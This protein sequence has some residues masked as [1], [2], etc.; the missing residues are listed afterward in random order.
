MNYKAVLFDLDGTLLNTLED[1]A[2]SMNEALKIM[3]LPS[4]PV[5]KYKILVGDGVDILVS[6]A[7]PENLRSKENI[8]RGVSL[9]RGEYDKRW[10][11]KTKPYPGIPEL[12][13]ALTK[14]GIKKAVLS[15]KPDD[16]TRIVVEKL[17]SKWRFDIVR[18]LKP[19]GPKKPDPS[20]AL[21]ISRAFGIPPDEFIYLGDTNTDM[22]TAN[23]AGMFAA[24]ALWGFRDR[25]ELLESG[26]KALIHKP[27][28]LKR[29]F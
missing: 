4:H 26:A 19:G 25:D 27:V 10:A 18:G 3:G 14:K 15:N 5:E 1:L 28:E 9:M 24:G 7:L 6:R 12:L 13:D 2:G 23:A 21:E 17:L 29:F 16:F 11:V 8:T 20:A 22:L